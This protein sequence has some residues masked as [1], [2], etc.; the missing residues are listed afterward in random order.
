MFFGSRKKIKK[1]RDA[2]CKEADTFIQVHFVRERNNDRYKFNTLP[3]KS[4]PERDKVSEWYDSGT[5]T[6]E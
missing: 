2:L 6:V 3:L 4:D 5:L 1:R